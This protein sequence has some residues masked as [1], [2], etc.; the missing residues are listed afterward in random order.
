[1]LEGYK[2]KKEVK[3][4]EP[5]KFKVGDIVKGNSKSDGRYNFTNSNM[6]RGKVTSVTGDTITIEVLEHK[7]RNG[8]VGEKYDV[9]P[10][11]FDLV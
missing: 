7:T 4:K 3:Q 1:M 6:T 2:P 10:K 5:H 11:Y 9:D 8:K